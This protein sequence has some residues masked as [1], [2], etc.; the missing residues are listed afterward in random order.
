M[1]VRKMDFRMNPW[2]TYVPVLFVEIFKV[3]IGKI[4][5]K[6]CEE[7]SGESLQRT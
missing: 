6:T 5:T 3:E 2:I 7:R 4:V 1:R